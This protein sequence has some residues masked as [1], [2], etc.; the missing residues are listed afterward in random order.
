M[1][2]VSFETIEGIGSRAEALEVAGRL[3]A[4]GVR[5]VSVVDT[6]GGYRLVVR[7]ADLTRARELIGDDRPDQ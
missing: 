1:G 4:G 7:S 5:V 6:E 2:P 3:A